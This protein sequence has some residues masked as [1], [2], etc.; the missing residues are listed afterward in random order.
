MTT[1]QDIQKFSPGALVDLYA[2]D[3]SMM[4]S[5]IFYF[6]GQTNE[7]LEPIVFDGTTHA[8]LPCWGEG[9]ARS[10][11][12]AAPRPTFTVDNTHKVVQSAVLSAGDLVGAIFTRTQVF[13]RYLDAVNFA[14]GT[15]PL[16]NPTQILSRDVYIVDKL[17]K[18]SKLQ[19]TWELCWAMDLPG[20]KL[21]R[22]Q[23]LR[24]FGF[25]GVGLNRA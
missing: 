6:C 11:S 15:N 2:V 17:T 8:T 1:R 9:W 7:K 22:Q 24:D 12:G 18:H 20:L 14:S 4:D 16:A 13:A 5:G 23:V 25:P 19:F 21:P 3:G 10:V